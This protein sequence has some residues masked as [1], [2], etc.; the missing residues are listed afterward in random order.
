M[1]TKSADA[2]ANSSQHSLGG[3]ATRDGI[4]GYANAVSVAGLAFDYA[5]V[6]IALLIHDWHSQLAE[7]SLCGGP[8]IFKVGGEGMAALPLV[9]GISGGA[10]GCSS[11]GNP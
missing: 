10:A 2:N 5:V 3:N 11:G 8:N 7:R 1:I 9:V 4:Q 6:V